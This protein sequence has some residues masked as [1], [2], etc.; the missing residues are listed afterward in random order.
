MLYHYLELTKSFILGLSW[1]AVV[2]I[3]VFLFK[4]QLKYIMANIKL[5]K[6]PGGEFETHSPHQKDAKPL[7]E[8]NSDLTENVAAE[9]VLND[10]LN[11]FHQKTIDKVNTVILNETHIDNLVKAEDKLDVLLSYTKLIIIEKHFQLIYSY[12]YG[13]QIELLEK[14]KTNDYETKESLKIFYE[15]AVAKNPNVYQNYSY[16]QY[17]AWLHDNGLLNVMENN[18]V[19]ISYEGL[20]FL[21]YLDLRQFIKTKS[22]Y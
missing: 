10:S 6:V 2:L 11:K 3:V 8:T 19:I 1:P 18:N 5:F 16:G 21:T 14:L 22:I 12:I 7:D 4:T 17:L 20:D 13:S 15:K 9:S